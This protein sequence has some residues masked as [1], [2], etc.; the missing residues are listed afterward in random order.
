MLLRNKKAQNLIEY[1]LVIAVLSSAAI[2][3]STYIYRAVQSKQQQI[4]EQYGQ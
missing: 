1:T 2:M 3:M 4:T